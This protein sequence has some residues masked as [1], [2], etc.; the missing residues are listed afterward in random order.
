MRRPVRTYARAPY[1][2][3]FAVASLLAT[4][5]LLLQGVAF[6]APTRA[7]SRAALHFASNGNFD[8]AGSYVPAAAGFNV[9]D[10]SSL[11]QLDS[12]PDGVKGLV[13]IG[14]CNGVD[15]KFLDAVRPY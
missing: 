7:N 5:V 11:A 13:W 3:W 12:L 8:S 6:D 2:A 4:G 1:V 10:V 15:T 14:Q 9:S